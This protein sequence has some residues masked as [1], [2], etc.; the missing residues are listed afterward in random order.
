[1]NVRTTNVHFPESDIKKDPLRIHL[2][3]PEQVVVLTVAD[4]GHPCIT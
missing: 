4:L 3:E 1:M 2:Y